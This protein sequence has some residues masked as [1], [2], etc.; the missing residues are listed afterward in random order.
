[1][2]TCTGISVDYRKVGNMAEVPGLK[3]EINAV[4]ARLGAYQF[5]KINSRPFLIHFKTDFSGI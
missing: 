4:M 1:M 2:P 3:T 5:S